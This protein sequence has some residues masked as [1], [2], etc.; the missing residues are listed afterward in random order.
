MD[1]LIDVHL[2]SINDRRHQFILKNKRNVYI[3]FLIVG[4]IILLEMMKISTRSIMQ[5]L[6]LVFGVGVYWFFWI[7]QWFGKYLSK[8]FFTAILYT[9]GILYPWDSLYTFQS[10]LLVFVFF[11]IVLHHLKVFLHIAGKSVGTDLVLIEVFLVISLVI[12]FVLW[13]N[14]LVELIP[15]CITLGVQLIIRY[16][17]PYGRMKAIAEIAYWSPILLIIYELL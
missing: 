17:Y 5:G 6:L 13:G 2:D 8:E 1:R 10:I 15:L 16:F 7:Q 9:L 12:C 14:Q 4:I 11:L 3:L